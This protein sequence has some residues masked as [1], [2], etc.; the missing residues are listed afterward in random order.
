MEYTNGRAKERRWTCC[1]N[2]SVSAD[3]RTRQTN[4]EGGVFDFV[5]IFKDAE[6]VPKVERIEFTQ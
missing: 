2:I 1:N 5:M 3:I 6:S 4:W